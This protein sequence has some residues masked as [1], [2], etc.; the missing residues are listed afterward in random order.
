VKS[1]SFP[2]V[3]RPT[4]AFLP[5][6]LIALA[7]LW[8]VDAFVTANRMQG[9]RLRLWLRQFSPP[10][11]ELA[12]A[13]VITQVLD[14]H[15]PFTNFPPVT[16]DERLENILESHS[17]HPSLALDLY[18]MRTWWPM[19]KEL[20]RTGDTEILSRLAYATNTVLDAA[21]RFMFPP[22]VMAFNDHAVAD[23]TE[24]LL[25][26]LSKLEQLKQMSELQSRLRRHILHN[27]ALLYGDSTFT[28]Q[29]N[30]GLMQIRAL[31]H[32]AQALPDTEVGRRSRAA[33]VARIEEM[34]PF[35]IADDGAVLEAAS[36]YWLLIYKEW[37]YIARISALPSRLRD[38][39]LTRL[40]KTAAFLDAVVNCEGFL[41]G[42]GDSYSRSLKGADLTFAGRAAT[43][44]SF[45]NGLVGFEYPTGQ[46]CTQVLFV[47]LDT[48]PPIH[49]MPEDLAVYVFAGEPFFANSGT[50]AYDNSPRRRYV[51]A[52]ENQSTVTWKDET[53]FHSSRLNA[54]EVRRGVWLLSGEKFGRTGRITREVRFAPDV[55][56]L[57]ITDRAERDLTARFNLHPNV[58]AEEI[59]E[60]ELLL[61]GKKGSIRLR[62][63]GRRFWNHRWVA[64]ANFTQTPIRQ[65]EIVGNPITVEIELPAAASLAAPA[66]DTGSGYR[67]RLELSKE[68]SRKYRASNFSRYESPSRFV[69]LR[70]AILAVIAGTASLLLFAPLAK[71]GRILL[72][73]NAVFLAADIAAQGLLATALIVLVKQWGTLLLL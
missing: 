14:Y 50:Y 25:L 4:S 61:K 6:A 62:H 16:L 12:P 2:Q 63:D 39:I 57:R 37:A 59:D 70:L 7:F 35:L 18:S 66:G 5:A 45:S 54:P 11:L 29:T 9:D 44:F 24:F 27:A 28:W 43:V 48:P 1:I 13:H 58:R 40:A 3:R 71:L 30:H 8:T 51:L 42:L 56:Q 19:L 36:T 38:L 52:G 53:L 67:R 31:L 32:L 20:E 49:K 46:S 41:Q 33:A 69:K 68:L 23:R 60:R 10:T 22:E 72:A 17:L 21:E 65:L 26:F 15:V 34:L 73:L 64:T 47:S 55:G